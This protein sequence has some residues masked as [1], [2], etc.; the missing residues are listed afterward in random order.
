VPEAGGVQAALASLFYLDG[1]TPAADEVQAC[2]ARYPDHDERLS[3]SRCG[4]S[5]K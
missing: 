2:V 3:R 5:L 1:A 4:L